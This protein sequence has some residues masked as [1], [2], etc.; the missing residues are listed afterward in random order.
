MFWVSNCLVT[1]EVSP[2]TH[3]GPRTFWKAAAAA[4]RRGMAGCPRSTGTG[5]QEGMA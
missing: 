5:R 1:S 2:R 4:G 3:F